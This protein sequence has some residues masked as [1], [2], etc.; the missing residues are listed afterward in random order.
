[1]T[2]Q[3]CQSDKKHKVRGVIVC[4]QHLPQPDDLLEFELPLEGDKNPAE[5]EEQ[6]EGPGAFCLVSS[7]PELVCVPLTE[8]SV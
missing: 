6:V 7:F 5:T 3:D 1:M 2:L 4:P 8:M